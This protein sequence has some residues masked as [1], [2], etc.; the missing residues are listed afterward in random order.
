MGCRHEGWYS[1]ATLF[2]GTL[3]WDGQWYAGMGVVQFGMFPLC[4]FFPM[5]HWDGVDS[6]MQA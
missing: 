3:G 6:E 2:H 5:E 4:P 1:L